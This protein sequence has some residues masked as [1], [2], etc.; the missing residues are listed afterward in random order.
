MSFGII[1][2]H[3]WRRQ[4]TGSLGI[5]ERHWLSAA[6]AD[7][8][9]AFWIL[10]PGRAQDA[11][12]RYSA[13]NGAVAGR[14]FQ[15]R[16]GAGLAAEFSESLSHQISIIS[17]T[18]P[19][20]SAWSIWWLQYCDDLA[21]VQYPAPWGF[22]TGA[23]GGNDQFRVFHGP[24][25]TG[26]EPLTFGGSLAG[27]GQFRFDSALA[28]SDLTGAWHWL[29]ITFTGGTRTTAA[30]Y[31]CYLNGRSVGSALAWS[32][33]SSTTDETVFGGT[34]NGATYFDGAMA[35]LGVVPRALSA[36]QMAALYADPYGLV[37][38][39]T[40]RIYIPS[41]GA[42]GGT[43]SLAVTLGALTGSAAGKL[44]IKGSS[45]V[46]LGSL[47]A[48]GAGALAIKG[49]SA[50]TLGTLT[51]SS[52]GTLLAT[53]SGSAAI[54]LGALTAA[55]SGKLEIKGQFA[56]TMGSLSAAAAGTLA[57]KGTSAVT[58]GALTLSS[59]GTLVTGTTGT[60]A[61]TL[62]ALTATATGTLPITGQ[63]AVTLGSLT[64]SATGTVP[65][66]GVLGIQLG[67]LTL[68]AYQTPPDAVTGALAVTLGELVVA[69]MSAPDLTRLGNRQV[70]ESSLIVQHARLPTGRV[71]KGSLPRIH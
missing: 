11:G 9:A 64:A 30:N 40:R 49:T 18:L 71:K 6:F 39:L 17:Y 42:G 47:A 19:V 25:S 29:G 1:L 3:R 41:A 27:S 61:I 60:A 59:S 55:A 20:A 50:V 13:I 33:I 58:L 44:D 12:R 65:I 28:G 46:T 14:A 69:A 22:K 66:T 21:G 24:S 10:G 5:D 45:A 32:G 43:G 63:A 56:V 48:S 53:G 8:G 15:S 68:A 2:P 7:L 52:A 31:Q 62:G 4:P 35:Y 70:R 37:R 67:A 54:T 23:A 36:G 16:A 34:S 26:Y 38:P 57:I 51:L